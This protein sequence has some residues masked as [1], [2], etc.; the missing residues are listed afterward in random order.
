MTNKKST[1]RALFA[2]MLAMLLSFTMLLGTT[3]A[4]FTDSVTSQ[5]NMIMAGNLDVELYYVNDEVTTWKKV[6]A[7]T[8]VFKAGTLWEPGHTEVIYLKV[9]N[10][11]SLS[12]KYQLGI[13][14]VSE[15]IGT[16][17]YNEPLKLSDYIEFD[18]IDIANGDFRYADRNAARKETL[19]AKFITDGFSKSSEIL[20]EN[21]PHYV[22]LVVY[23]PE[24]VGNEAN[25]IG[26]IVPTINLG[27]TLRAT[28]TADESDSFGNDYDA[29][30]T[31][32]KP[33]NSTADTAWYTGD[34]TEYSLTT[35]EELAGLAQLVNAGNSFN[36][37]TVKLADD[38]D[39]AD[40]PW[41][42]IGIDKAPFGG[43]LDGNHYVIYNLNV[44]GNE[45]VGLVGIAGNAASIE[46]ITVENATVTGNHYVGTILGYGYLSA[47]SLAGCFVNNATVVCTPDTNNDNGDKAGVIAGVAI[48]GNIYNN[49]VTNSKV[50]AYRDFGSIVGMAQAE[51]RDIN[52]YSNS[53][54]DVELIYINCENYADTSKKNS[55][56]GALVGR[57]NN[58]G[59][60]VTVAN[61][62]KTVGIIENTDAVKVVTPE[63]TSKI[64]KDETV[65]FAPGV[66]NDIPSL[67]ENSTI[68]GTD[69]VVFNDTLSGTMNNTTIKNVEISAPNAQRWAYSKGTLVFEDCTFEA[70]SVYAIHYDGLNGA[71]ITYKNCKIV[72]WVAI[73][74]GA[75]HITF[76][77]CEIYGNGRYGVIRLYSPGTIKNCTFDVSAV[78]TTD[79]YQDGIHAV[80]C[81]VNVENVINVNGETEDLFN[82][83]GTG[84]IKTITESG[85]EVS[86]VTTAAGLATALANGGEVKMTANVNAGKQV[87]VNSGVLDGNGNTITVDSGSAAYESGLTVTQGT[88]KNITVA[89]AFRGLGVGGSGASEMTGDVTYENV[90]VKDATYGVNIGVGN[91]YKLT[92]INST[93]CDWNSY[94][95]LGS[96]Q[97]TGCTFTSEGRYYASQRI[98][99]GATFTY[100]NCNFEQNTYNNVN[101]SDNY[102]LN[103]YNGTGTIVF[104]N[105]YIDGVLIT[106]DNVSDYFQISDV[107]VVVK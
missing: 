59:K 68:I 61:S 33:W 25:Y 73:G 76:D 60:T 21:E 4:W 79:V 24:L 43:T 62:N 85:A 106:A 72:G 104:E 19:N 53:A 105:C 2:S 38:M 36:G 50:Y 27:I 86:N 102:Y 65:Y 41:T 95:G 10:E 88:V 11:G 54:E 40:R 42:P 75:E 29:D 84:I 83:S 14:I 81:T 99:A 56:M 22:A 52:V 100:T 78:N 57:L 74:G 30:A 12:L 9:V 89:G 46:N 1:K 82:I 15:V 98:S 7:D 70:T 8:N 13:N 55:N 87:F 44:S 90:T 94:S 64:A 51:N 63:T 37:I 32:L 17:V 26:D 58:A 91:G 34:K 5:N 71:N 103:S 16:N 93:I 6:D 80:D 69:G 23:M 49:K 31:F 3:Y 45:G 20:A 48:N 92:V 18:V 66:Y 107:K 96:A 28:Q 39:L 35:P 77:G 47:N 101:G 67:G 97:F